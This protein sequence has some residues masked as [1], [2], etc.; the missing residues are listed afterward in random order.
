MAARP[1]SLAHSV[2]RKRLTSLPVGIRGPKTVRS[3]TLHDF[4]SSPAEAFRIA[5]ERP[6]EPSQPLPQDIGAILFDRVPGF[7]LRVTPWQHGNAV[8]SVAPA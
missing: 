5:V 4:A 1:E 6:V 7:I 8:A 2:G 3:V